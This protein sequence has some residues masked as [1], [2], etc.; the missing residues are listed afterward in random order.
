MST[1]PDPTAHR[2]D[3]PG[4]D[5]LDAPDGAVDRADNGAVDAAGGLAPDGVPELPWEPASAYS[6]EGYDQDDPWNA[7]LCVEG[8]STEIVLEL[9][10]T[11]LDRLVAGLS[12]VRD[13]QRRALGAGADEPDPGEE[14]HG[15][16]R[17]TAAARVA[18]GSAP[19]AQ[20]WNS[21]TNGRLIIIGG[22]VLFVLLGAILSLVL[23]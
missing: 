17:V 16:G 12:D 20:L 3:Q 9:T 23:Q 1:T 19:V 5:A 18:T 21:G 10:P 13:A 2:V 6:I 4:T 22:V 7:V 15:L 11:H 14:H 8:Q